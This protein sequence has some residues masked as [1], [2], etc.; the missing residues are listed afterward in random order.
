M[1][2]IGS[3]YSKEFQVENESLPMSAAIKNN[4]I[5]SHRVAIASYLLTPA[6]QHV[7]SNRVDSGSAKI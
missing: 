1:L 5:C 7:K 4:V 6:L 2:L 3:G